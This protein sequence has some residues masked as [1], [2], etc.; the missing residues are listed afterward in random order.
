MSNPVLHTR[1][2]RRLAQQT[3]RRQPLCQ[4]RLPGCTQYSTTADHIIPVAQRPDLALNPANTQGAC[5]H[6]NYSRGRT[7]ITHLN[8][9]NRTSKAAGFF[10]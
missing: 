4:L 10:N 2:W 7:P 3:I 1:A 5:K 9:H 8:T 6:C